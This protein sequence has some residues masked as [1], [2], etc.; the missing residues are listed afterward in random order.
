MITTLETLLPGGERDS[1]SL[2]C[3]LFAAERE[4]VAVVGALAVLA[5]WEVLFQ[6]ENDAASAD[7]M[8][9]ASYWLES[10]RAD[11]DRLIAELT[12]MVGDE[13]ARLAPWRK[14]R[15]DKETATREAAHALMG[16]AATYLRLAIRRVTI[17]RLEDATAALDV[18]V[19]AEESSDAG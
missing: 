14:E 1:I 7:V 10:E 18:K 5:G 11:L 12:R 3:A 19:L 17:D 4:R 2:H 8:T 16:L 6:A 9:A 15:L 13:A